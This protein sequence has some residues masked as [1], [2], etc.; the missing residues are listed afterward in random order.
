MKG[1]INLNGGIVIE[2]KLEQHLYLWASVLFYSVLL[3]K[4][5]LKYERFFSWEFIKKNNK[6]CKKKKV[7]WFYGKISI[8]KSE[9]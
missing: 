6:T 4:N 3:G 5:I 7:Y 8:D 9:I 2:T 1:R